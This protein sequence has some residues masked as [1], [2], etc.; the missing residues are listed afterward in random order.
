MPACLLKTIIAFNEIFTVELLCILSED[1]FLNFEGYG[2]SYMYFGLKYEFV[3]CAVN[4]SEIALF[5]LDKAIAR[6]YCCRRWRIF[7]HR[8]LVKT[9]TLSFLCW[10]SIDSDKIYN[11]Q[12]D[13]FAVNLVASLQYNIYHIYNI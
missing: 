4:F 12:I 5:A 3:L 6:I 1:T 8:C 11:E 10:D 13:L 7:Q 9:R 2:A